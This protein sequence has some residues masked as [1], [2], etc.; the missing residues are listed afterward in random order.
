MKI[1]IQ[2]LNDIDNQSWPFKIKI[3]MAKS[4]KSVMKEAVDESRMWMKT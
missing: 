3:E 1:E 2:I 4:V